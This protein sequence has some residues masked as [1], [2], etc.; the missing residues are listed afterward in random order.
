[1]QAIGTTKHTNAEITIWIKNI[2][3]VNEFSVCKLRCPE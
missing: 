3:Q 1:M 2:D